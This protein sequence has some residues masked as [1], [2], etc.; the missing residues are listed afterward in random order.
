M[1]P[2][3]SSMILLATAALFCLLA[4]ASPS[5]AP[6]P[7]T[8][9]APTVE[10]IR[11]AV[12]LS[13]LEADVSVIVTS[14]LDSYTGGVRCCLIAQGTAR[15]GTNLN[16]ASIE[17]IDPGA[18]T[19]ELTLTELRVLELGLSAFPSGWHGTS[20]LRYDRVSLEI[21]GPVM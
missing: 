7:G 9:P 5:N 21:S 14:R 12:E 13:V 1:M 15:I 3:L 11:E 17:R 6:S 16:E 10:L 18:K 8:T 4:T 2:R 19:L 20:F